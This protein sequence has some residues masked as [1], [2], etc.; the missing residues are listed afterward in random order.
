M[1]AVLAAQREMLLYF[2]D[3]WRAGVVVVAK[4][5][6]LGPLDFPLWSEK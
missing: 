3:V 6:K 5:W 4:P 2:A 1:F